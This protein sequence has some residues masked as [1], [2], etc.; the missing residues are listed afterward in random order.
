MRGLKPDLVLIDEWR[1]FQLPPLDKGRI[2]KNPGFTVV[3]ANT[4][5]LVAPAA[6]K[7]PNVEQQTEEE[8]VQLSTEVSRES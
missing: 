4:S 5:E 3:K 7:G 6:V 2:Y 1:D 8:N